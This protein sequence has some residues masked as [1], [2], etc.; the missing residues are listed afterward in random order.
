MVIA[1]VALGV[2][3]SGTS[4]ARILALPVNSV[5][6]AQLKANAVI[7]SKVKNNSLLAVDFKPGQLPVPG[8]S[9][10]EVVEGTTSI[11]MNQ[12]YNSLFMTCPAGKKA[13][14]GG[15]GTGGGIIPGDGP[16]IVVNAPSVDG[17]SWLVQTARGTSGYSALTGRVLCANVP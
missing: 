11:V 4:Y 2:A 7:S 17:S 8:I 5:G 9:G 3:L 6:T 16:Y 10:Y 1:C 13:I 12:I 15:G 14:G